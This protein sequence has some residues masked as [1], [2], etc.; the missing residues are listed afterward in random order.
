MD[1][2]FIVDTLCSIDTLSWVDTV[3]VTVYDSL[4]AASADD[5]GHSLLTTLAPVAGAVIGAAVTFWFASKLM[6]KRLAEER[7]TRYEDRQNDSWSRL[8]VLFWSFDFR[9]S[10]LEDLLETLQRRAEGQW[11]NFDL[12]LLEWIPETELIRLLDPS[13]SNKEVVK[14]F[15]EFTRDVA[16][17]K[18]VYC[19]CRKLSDSGK[20]NS[21]AGCLGR[22]TASFSLRFD[23]WQEYLE[24][25][26][27][28]VV[29]QGESPFA[30]QAMIDVRRLMETDTIEGDECTT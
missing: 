13:V 11:L 10:E 30:Y 12:A 9:I 29:S 7:K 5:G 16:H 6:R 8:E 21:A 20:R 14:Y 22:F 2:L 28:Y 25:L 15:M 17:L 3:A 23:Y 26:R 27:E 24:P 1:T 19:E 4:R 18:A